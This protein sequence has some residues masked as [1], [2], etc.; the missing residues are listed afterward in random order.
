MRNTSQVAFD[1]HLNVRLLLTALLGQSF[2]RH[3]G[4]RHDCA[5]YVAPEK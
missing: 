2:G 4:D 1:A 3:R 5:Y